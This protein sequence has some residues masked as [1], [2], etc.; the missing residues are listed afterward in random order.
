MVVRHV[1][2]TGG[3]IVLRLNDRKMSMEKNVEESGLA[4]RATLADVVWQVFSAASGGYT[5]V[6]GGLEDGMGW[7]CSA[8]PRYKAQHTAADFYRFFLHI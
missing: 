8:L 5:K 7:G 6:R 4:G 1:A 2:R 3:E